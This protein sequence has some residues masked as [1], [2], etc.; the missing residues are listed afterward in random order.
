VT[1]NLLHDNASDDVFCEMQHG[2][3][4]LANNFCLSSSAVLVNSKS[5]AFAH[6]LLAGAFSS[7][8]YDPRKTPWHPPHATAI[9]GLADAPSGD[10]RFYNNLAWGSHKPAQGRPLADIKLP[11]A[12]DGNVYIL[13]ARPAAFDATATVDTNLS[14][15]LK[16]TRHPDGWY[17]NLAEAPE[18][19]KTKRPLVNTA[20]LGKAR[21]PN[22]PYENR[23]GTPLAVDADYFGRKRDKDNPFPGPFETPVN[24]EVKVWPKP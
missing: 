17:L 18:W 1:A 20:M 15:Q 7:V 6:N 13:G 14:A 22:A 12:A 24:G 10:H 23:D 19:K 9:A 8:P 3:M 2:P 11:C 16:L 21:I 4:L 5:L